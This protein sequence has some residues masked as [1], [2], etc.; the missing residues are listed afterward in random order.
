MHQEECDGLSENW[1]GDLDWNQVAQNM[2]DPDE[3]S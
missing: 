2:K 3:D 1:P